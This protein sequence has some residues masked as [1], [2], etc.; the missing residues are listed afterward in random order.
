MTDFTDDTCR[1]NSTPVLEFADAKTTKEILELRINHGD[2]K[3]DYYK[4]LDKRK[5]SSLQKARDQVY[6]THLEVRLIKRSVLI[7]N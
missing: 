1:F 6:N 2:S 3:S 7:T 5:D 4:E